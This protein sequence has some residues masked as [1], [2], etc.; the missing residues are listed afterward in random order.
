[1][2][3]TMQALALK[4]HGHSML[5]NA[6]GDLVHLPARSEVGRYDF[7]IGAEPTCDRCD[8]LEFVWSYRND[9]AGMTPADRER[10]EAPPLKA[11]RAAARFFGRQWPEVRNG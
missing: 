2:N 7:R 4:R 11:V 8:Y 5:R 1:M 9:I 10:F 3:A 6:D